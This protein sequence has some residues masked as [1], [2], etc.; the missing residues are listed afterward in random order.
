MAASHARPDKFHLI[1]AAALLLSAWSLT[2]SAASG[3]QALCPDTNSATLEISDTELNANTTA[4][5]GLPA[6][7]A[8]DEQGD[9]LGASQLLQPGPETALREAFTDNDATT[10]SGVDEA[11]SPQV[12]DDAVD[13]NTRVPGVADDELTR[14]KRQMFRRDI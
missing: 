9:A 5:D 2:A 1:A 14:Y 10:V 11:V 8:G 6:S 3:Y 4:H 12:S 7:T 13:I